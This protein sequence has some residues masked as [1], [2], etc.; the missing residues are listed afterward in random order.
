MKKLLIILT[1]FVLTISAK[2]QFAKP[3]GVH[4]P[5]TYKFWKNNAD[6]TITIYMGSV[7]LWNTLLS[8]FD[9]VKVKG[10]ATNFK[11]LSYLQKKDTTQNR[12]GY[13]PFYRYQFLMLK[14]DSSKY[15]GVGGASG[16]HRDI[17]SLRRICPRRE[18]G[19]RRRE[20]L[21]ADQDLLGRYFHS[22]YR[23]DAR[24]RE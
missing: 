20:A 16:H 17:C 13:I 3:A 12:Y 9:S 4:D 22:G 7:D 15:Y 2:A 21:L 10:Y 6:S 8:K 19:R 5:G 18:D 11:L 23:R 14:N 24:A 1:L